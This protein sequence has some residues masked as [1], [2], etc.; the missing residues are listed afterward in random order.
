MIK[1]FWRLFV[2]VG[3]FLKSRL[4]PRTVTM[5]EVGPWKQQT[6]S[7]KH[8]T[9]PNILRCNRH[10]HGT[11]SQQEFFVR[12][13]GVDNDGLNAFK[14]IPLVCFEDMIM[15]QLPFIWTIYQ[16][17]RWPFFLNFRPH[18]WLQLHRLLRK[19]SAD[20]LTHD[21]AGTIDFSRVLWTGAMAAAN[22]TR[23]CRENR[24][25]TLRGLF[26]EL[27]VM[28]GYFLSPDWSFKQHVDRQ[29]VNLFWWSINCLSHLS[30]TMFSGFSFS[31]VRISFFFLTFHTPND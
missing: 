7:S 14:T 15:R 29:K 10:K 8:G 24:K 21:T 19:P 27:I 30:S 31:N 9:K 11:K 12:A 26:T 4:Q 20:L 17:C 3:D 16:S 5:L 1:T 23:H 22:V 18:R 28:E 6:S 13:F 2:W 25:I